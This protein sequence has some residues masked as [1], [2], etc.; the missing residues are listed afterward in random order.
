MKSSVRVYELNDGL[1][2]LLNGTIEDIRNYMKNL[3]T[4]NKYFIEMTLSINLEEDYYAYLDND[5]NLLD[6]LNKFSYRIKELCAV[7]IEDFQ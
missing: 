4:S 7:P 2:V 3:Y 5:A 6:A 1:K